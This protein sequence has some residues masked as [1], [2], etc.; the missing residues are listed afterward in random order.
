MIDSPA[1]QK[2]G[3][4]IAEGNATVLVVL[5]C[6]DKKKNKKAE[7]VVAEVIGQVKEQTDAVEE[8]KAKEAK[9]AD[10]A[11]KD[12]A[13]EEEDDD[14]DFWTNEPEE[15]PQLPFKIATLKVSRT[16]KAEKWLVDS[17]MAVEQDLSEYADDPMI[18]AVYGRGRAMPPYI[19]KGISAENLVDCMQFLSGPCSC[20]VKD[21]NPGMDLMMKWDWEATVEAIAEATW[22][23]QQGPE[24]EEVDVD[25][26]AAKSEKKGSAGEA[27]T[28][29]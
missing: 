9:E 5:P 7:K 21:M 14:A 29:R 1:R 15:D 6:S 8:E 24:Y 10:K 17:L 20:Q 16:D 2:I 12:K 13:K 25:A 4:L 27:K 18:F 11:A 28:D 3:K 26:G 23:A 22:K 19:G